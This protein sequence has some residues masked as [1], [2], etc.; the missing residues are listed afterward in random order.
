MDPGASVF[1]GVGGGGGGPHFS[2]TAVVY[3]S[4]QNIALTT[5]GCAFPVCFSLSAGH[6]C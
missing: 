6:V 4:P 1:V 3:I 5:S 2:V